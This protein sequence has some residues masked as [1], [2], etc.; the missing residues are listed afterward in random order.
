MLV[1]NNHIVDSKP[2]VFNRDVETITDYLSIKTTHSVTDIIVPSLGAS[3]LILDAD[4]T[5]YKYNE[6]PTEAVIDWVLEASEYL[7][8]NLIVV[9][10]NRSVFPFDKVKHCARKSWYDYKFSS[11][12][13]KNAID[14]L[15]NDSNSTIFAATDSPSDI[16]SNR[17]FGIP[18]KNQFLVKSL[19]AHPK[20]EAA[21][22][23]FYPRIAKVGSQL[24]ARA[25]L[26]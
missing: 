4:G 6:Q 10:D 9:T 25:N 5:L 26:I 16:V 8:G 11:L 19:G 12:R 7:E 22:K 1:K 17:F 24:L 18:F 23:H 2:R 13:N 14:S 21:R 3:A 20:Q 15:R